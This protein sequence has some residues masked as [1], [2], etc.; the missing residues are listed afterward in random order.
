MITGGG[1]VFWVC[2]CVETALVWFCCC[3]L[4]ALVGLVG[5]RAVPDPG[6]SWLL[7]RLV[8]LLEGCQPAVSIV[9]LLTA[10]AAAGVHK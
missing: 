1:V 6:F 4:L 3:W 10:A 2:F 7:S 5:F 9:L 8:T